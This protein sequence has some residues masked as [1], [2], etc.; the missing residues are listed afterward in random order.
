MTVIAGSYDLTLVGFSIAAAVIAAYVSIDLLDM[1]LSAHDR[2]DRRKWHVFSA[3]SLGLGTW[4]M[5]F[6]GMF[7]Y[8]M[9]VEVHYD[10]LI[11]LG[12]LFVAIV[13][14]YIGIGY[15]RGSRKQISIQGAIFMGSGIASMHYLG[16]YAMH[17]PAE[18]SYNQFLVTL[19][20]VV[21]IAVS[22]AGLLIIKNL[23]DTR[24]IDSI[25]LK[26]M[27]AAVVGSAISSM[28]Y[29]GMA[30]M[31]HTRGHEHHQE[32]SD[33]YSWFVIDSE[34]M[35]AEVA[36][37][38]M[39]LLMFSFYTVSSER[40]VLKKL[41]KERQLLSNS[42]NRLSTLLD[43]IADAVVVIDMRGKISLFNHSAE[44]MFGYSKDEM[45]DKNVSILMNGKDRSRH[46]DYMHHYMRTGE[47]K[48][49]DIG[50]R[51]LTALTKDGNEILIGLSINEVESEEGPQFIGVMRDM[52]A[53]RRELDKLTQRA[54]Y[55]SLTGLLNRHAL[56]KRLEAAVAKAKRDESQACFMFI[57]LDGFKAVNDNHGHDAGDELLRQVAVL[58]REKTR[59]SDIVCRFGGDEFCILFE[60][61][62]G[63]DGMK[64]LSEKIVS[65]FQTPF[66]ILDNR[67][68]VTASIGV[69]FYPDDSEDDGDLLK[70]SDSAMYDAKHAGKNQYKFY[71]NQ[72][73]NAVEETLIETKCCPK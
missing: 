59:E 22:A 60:G 16:M 69:A 2:T 44:E 23:H 33:Q 47:S 71:D 58:L 41:K 35:M 46:D 49:I 30:A 72:C 25:P 40:S 53:H 54:D 4:I 36:I 18:H 15:I 31:E 65:A 51:Q 70:H 26:L 73:C 1:Y 68:E 48:I 38:G 61:I 20:V 56:F 57:D 11:T 24:R 27:A 55:D 28:H 3:I 6:L 29:L 19:S 12:S 43:N 45:I 34:F 21:A 8:Q 13:A 42:E 9:S 10:G 32:H 64:K 63:C 62:K 66:Q 50:T 39:I 52:T 37:A 17:M 67:A 14:C 7:A 5:H